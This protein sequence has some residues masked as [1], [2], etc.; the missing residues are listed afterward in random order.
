[1]GSLWCDPFPWGSIGPM[2]QVPLVSPCTWLSAHNANSSCHQYD[3]WSPAGVPQLKGEQR[4][5]EG[6]RS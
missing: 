2:A 4:G 6:M 1:M 3:P 5:N